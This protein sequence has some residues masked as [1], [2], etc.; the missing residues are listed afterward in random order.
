MIF[1]HGKQGVSAVRLSW[2]CL[3][4]RDTYENG[5]MRRSF[6][7]SCRDQTDRPLDWFVKEAEKQKLADHPKGLQSEKPEKKGGKKK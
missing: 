1:S 5:R 6:G 4:S 3:L 7:R 2:A